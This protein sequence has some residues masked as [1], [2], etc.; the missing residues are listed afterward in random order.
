MMKLWTVAKEQT[1][2]T[3]DDREMDTLWH[4]EVAQ[5]EYIYLIDIPLGGALSDKLVTDSVNDA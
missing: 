4:L 2:P 5:D 3:A 1:R